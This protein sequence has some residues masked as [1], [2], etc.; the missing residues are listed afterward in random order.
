MLS[1]QKLRN[2][3]GLLITIV[4]GLALV[5]FVLGD[6]MNP[7]KSSLFSKD[8]IVL[9]VNGQSVPSTEYFD[10]QKQLESNYQSNGQTID[11]NTRNMIAMQSW[12]QLLR[13]VVLQQEYEK[14]GLGVKIE[15]HGIIGITPK[16][17]RDLIVGN[18]VDPQIQQIFRNQETGAFDKSLAL[19][20]LQNMDKD[21]EKKQIW[22]TIEKQLIENR[23][24]TKYAALLTQGINTTTVEAKMLVKEKSHKVDISYVQVPFFTMPDSSFKPTTDELE[25]YLSKHKDEFKQE[26]SRDIDYVVFAVKASQADV[27]A[28]QKSVSDLSKDFKTTENDENFVNSNS[29]VGFDSKFHKKGTLPAAID[30]FAFNGSKGDMCAPY[31]DGEYIKV[32]KISKIQ[33]LADSVKAR[34]ILVTSPNA[35]QVIDSLKGAI[36]KGENFS[37]LAFKYSEDKGSKMKGGELGWFKEGQMVRPFNDTCF[38]G[39]VGKLYVVPTQYG[40]HLI[41]IQEKGVETKKVQLATLAAKIE[42]STATRNKIYADANKFAGEN[43]TAALFQKSIETNSKVDKRVAT[44]LKPADRVISGIESARQIVR[45][46]FE[47]KKGD[48]SSVFDCTNSFVVACIKA[49]REKGAAELESVK[50]QIE[51]EVIKEKK[52]A[53]IL[54]EISKAGS[55]ASLSD[56]ATKLKNVQVRDAA[57]IVFSTSGVAGVGLEPSVVGVAT[58]L[59]AGKVSKPVIGNSG[60]FVLVVNKVDETPVSDIKLEQDQQ[61]RMNKSRFGYYSFNVLKDKSDIVD[62]R[63]LFE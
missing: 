5:A 2:K 18:N 38:M 33:L 54:D 26:T 60:V 24:A 11:D 44:E 36:E 50:G 57:G 12:D 55:F 52:T 17:I 27:Q 20:F 46:M 47:S 4:I 39:K 48:V 42:A 56:L 32:S 21:P 19:N 6:I 23:M 45:W 7:K 3:A 37:V 51:P 1:I 40:F 61:T 43:N 34:H 53:K 15:E 49:T 9:K 16:E 25:A 8:N 28:I 41:E 31:F 13:Q 10:L 62:N 58:V 29:S 59:P 63:I 35:K 14:L 22:L 30:S